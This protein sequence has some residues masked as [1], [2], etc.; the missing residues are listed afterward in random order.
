MIIYT[1][2]NSLEIINYFGYGVGLVFRQDTNFDK[3]G[4][5]VTREIR[6][7]MSHNF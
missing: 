2:G 5:I 7:L 4:K 6:K 1:N 3:S